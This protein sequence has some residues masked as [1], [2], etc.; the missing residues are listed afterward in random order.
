M[1]AAA[2][3]DV[4]RTQFCQRHI[5]PFCMLC[6]NQTHLPR[7][8]LQG[9]NVSAFSLHPGTIGTTSIVR[10]V[11]PPGSCFGR[12]TEFLLGLLPNIGE[13]KSLQQVLLQSARNRKL[14]DY[15]QSAER[16]EV[17]PA[18]SSSGH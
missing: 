15:M 11:A 14:R 9:T 16:F 3:F 10:H 4:V 7:R 6:L 13:F 18:V 8:R 17:S 12:V 1:P 2:A 5:V